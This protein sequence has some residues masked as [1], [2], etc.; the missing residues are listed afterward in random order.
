MITVRRLIPGGFIV[1]VLLSIGPTVRLSAQVD[2]TKPP[3]LGATPALRLPP[4]G[5]ATLANGLR[6]VVVEMHEVPVVDVTVLVDAGSVHD[7]ADL[8][9][10][11]TF[12]ANMLDEGAGRRGALEIA[13]EVA[14]LGAQLNTAAGF[15]VATVTLHVPKRRLEPAL[16]LLADILLRPTFADSEITRQHDLRVAALLQLRD[17]PVQMAGVAFPAIVFGSAHPYGRPL[18]GTDSSTALLSRAR[19]RRFYDTVYRPNGAQLLVVGDV[20]LTE[21]RRL[22]DQRFGAWARGDVPV[23]AE[24]KAPAPPARTIYLVDK[25]GAPQSV[26]RIGHAGVARATPDYFA[27]EVLNTILGGSFTSRLNQNLRE[28]HGYTYGASSSFAMRRM[29]GPFTASA[30]VVTDKTDSS[31]VEFLKELRRIRDEAVPPAELEKAK[32]YIVLGLPGNFETTGGSAAQYRDLL[33]YD[34]PLDYYASY[35][36]G[37]TAVTAADV[38]RVARRYVDPDHFAIV[39][40]GDRSLIESGIQALN[41]G[42]IARRD[43]WG[44]PLP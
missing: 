41:E 6:L 21:I 28:T 2:R 35:M 32:S 15:D 11:A 25:P 34:L 17:Q 29:A 1:A 27:L 19:V 38:Q 42:P 36:A 16:D 9:G 44:N 18:N 39:V 23:V 30:S 40:V 33:I 31:L 13:E 14:Y 12:T 22:I 43:L 3:T 8:P 37:I 24:A 4:E 7:P 5:Q 10:L 20:T 26:I